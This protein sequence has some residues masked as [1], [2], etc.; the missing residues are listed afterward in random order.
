LNI[1]L[2]ECW[3]FEN[4]KKREVKMKVSGRL[5]VLGADD[6]EMK[7]IVLFLE[8]NGEEYIFAT[9]DGKR[10]HPGN[11]YEA[12]NDYDLSEFSEIVFVECWVDG[13]E[14]NKIIDHHRPGDPG[15]GKLPELYWEAS[16]LG[17]LHAFLEVDPAPG[18]K[19]LAAMDHCFNAAIQGLCPGVSAEEVLEVKVKDGIM[20]THNVSR[21]DVMTIISNWREQFESSDNDTVVIGGESVILVDEHTGFGYSLLYLTAQV[22]AVLCHKPVILRVK[23][24]VNAPVDRLMLCGDVSGETVRNFLADNPLNLERLFGSPERGYAG[25]YD[26]KT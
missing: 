15:C 3:L 17:Q 18:D 10:T 13:I 24:T 9:R 8:E 7:R 2:A 23:D 16:S 25:G 12:N 4:Y 1:L 19:I 21:E 20:A 11:A 6:P 26:R 22:A 14:P 5:F